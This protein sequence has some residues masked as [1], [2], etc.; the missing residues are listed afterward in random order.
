M[1]KFG[2]GEFLKNYWYIILLLVIVIP[3][4]FVGG[5]WLANG[6]CTKDFDWVTF[7]GAILSYA[8]TVLISL[9]AI[10]QSEKA[11]LLSEMVYEL[12]EQE[13]YAIFAI[14]AVESNN[15]MKCPGMVTTS[16]DIPL[17][18][19]QFC[20]VDNTP[21]K[22]QGFRIRILNCSKYPITYIR[23]KTTYTVGRKGLDESLEQS[24]NCLIMPNGIHDYFVCNSPYFIPKGSARVFEVTC[25]NIFDFSMTLKLEIEAY[26]KNENDNRVDYSC[27]LLELGKISR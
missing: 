22:C 20:N 4:L 25:G 2:F 27:E 16:G 26:G 23:I 1:T 14:E 6:F 7:C 11:T 9:V 15:N 13:H 5:I 18:R 12:N 8:G 3:S 21:E 19:M 17:T 24:S 10:Y